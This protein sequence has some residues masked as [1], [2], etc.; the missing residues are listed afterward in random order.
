MGPSCTILLG[1]TIL[2]HVQVCLV[3]FDNKCHRKRG[4]GPVVYNTNILTPAYLAM[5]V[6]KANIYMSFTNYE[7]NGYM[8]SL[9]LL[10]NSRQLHI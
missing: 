10:T 1:V 5:Y 7:E 2:P 4:G 3:Y 8:H 9:D 6:V